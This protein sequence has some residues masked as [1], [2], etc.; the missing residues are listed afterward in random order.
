MPPIFTL[1]EQVYHF[2]RKQRSACGGA[3]YIQ[4]T[5]FLVSKHRRVRMSES[6]E[7]SLLASQSSSSS[8]F[9]GQ[10]R[11]GTW[12]FMQQEFDVKFNSLN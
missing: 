1:D 5:C 8:S 9:T 11:S 3:V 2:K 7:R 4:S 6:P 10:R 12:I